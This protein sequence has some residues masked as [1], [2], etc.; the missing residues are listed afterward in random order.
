MQ[1]RY[2]AIKIKSNNQR[3]RPEDAEGERSILQRITTTNP[4][5][6][7]WHY[8]R[9][10]LDSFEVTGISGEHTCLVFQP[11]R[12]PLWMFCL[13]YPDEVIPFDMIKLMLRMLLPALDYLHSECNI[14]HADLKLDNIMIRLEDP[15][16]LDEDARDAYA[17]PLPEKHCDDGRIIYLSR[18][19]WGPPRGVTGYVCIHDFDSAV[20][21]NMPHYGSIQAEVYRAPEVILEADFSYAADIWSLGAL[22]WNLLEG[23][24]LFKAIDPHITGEYDD[25]NHLA[26]ITALLGVPPKELLEKGRK[27]SLLYDGNGVLKGPKP[28]PTD[29]SFDHVITNISGEEKQMFIKFVKRMLQ[30]RPE[31]RSTAAELLKDPW[32]YD[33]FPQD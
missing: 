21:G 32:L 11:L 27:T 16:I 17:N 23:T 2:V 29:F 10:L 18:N 31:D 19:N 26:Y 9:K 15:A 12:E 1:E 24:R 7:G 28:I 3:S 20:D 14:I 22:L 30:W 8:V 33:N 5:H 4:K 13:R 6:D 25:A